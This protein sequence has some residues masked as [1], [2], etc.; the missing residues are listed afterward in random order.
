M[1]SHEYRVYS[2]AELQA[3]GLTHNLLRDEI[4]LSPRASER[5]HPSTFK[6]K[7]MYRHL[8]DDDLL[9]L[10]AVARPDDVELFREAARRFERLLLAARKT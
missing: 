1:A 5:A 2:E 6:E 4:I 8:S 3:R 9:R 10:L 7:R